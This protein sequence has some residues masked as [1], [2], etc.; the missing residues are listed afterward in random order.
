MDATYIGSGAADENR[1]CTVFA[2]TFVLG[3]PTPIDDLPAAFIQKL[4]GNG[5]FTVEGDLK[6]IPRAQLAA[7]KIPLLEGDVLIPEGWRE[8]TWF[9]MAA[10]AKEIDDGKRPENK[11]RAEAIIEEEIGRRELRQN[12]ANLIAARQ[13]DA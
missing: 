1:L 13:A 6:K 2:R 12:T 9:K 11:E 10:L 4:K 8:L 3:E 7:G 5:T